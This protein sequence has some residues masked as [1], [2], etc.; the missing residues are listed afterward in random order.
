MGS[1][2]TVVELQNISL[3]TIACIIYYVC[4]YILASIIRVCKT[5]P[6]VV[7]VVIIIIIIIIIIINCN[8]V[9]NRWQWLF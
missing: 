2:C 3:L 1:L 5:H 4:V 6:L 8:F 7:V 9:V